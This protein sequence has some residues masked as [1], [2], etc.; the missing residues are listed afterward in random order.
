[1]HNGDAHL[2]RTWENARSN[3]HRLND[4]VRPGFRSLASSLPL[5]RSELLHAQR[6]KTA[7]ARV[8][9]QHVLCGHYRDHCHD[10]H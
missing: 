9:V 8:Q 10:Q 2:T 4:Y 7:S 5:G 3:S 1:M 6:T